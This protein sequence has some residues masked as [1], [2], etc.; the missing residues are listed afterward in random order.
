MA[1]LRNINQTAQEGAKKELLGAVS[2]KGAMPAEE[3]E[4]LHST[5]FI[6]FAGISAV[7]YVSQYKTIGAYCGIQ[8]DI[9]R[10]GE[11]HP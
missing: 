10:T 6:I 8:P 2:G 3:K 9:G 7:S 5:S 11:N 4:F 1:K